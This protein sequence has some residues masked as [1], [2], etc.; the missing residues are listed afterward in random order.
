[1]FA[2]VLLFVPLFITVET[3]RTLTSLASCRLWYHGC[4]EWVAPLAHSRKQF[5]VLYVV[6]DVRDRLFLSRLILLRPVK[7]VGGLSVL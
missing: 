3:S 7:S 6:A 2:N 5:V 1:M 4:R